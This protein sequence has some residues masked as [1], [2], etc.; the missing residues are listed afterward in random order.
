MVKLSSSGYH[1]TKQQII[2]RNP[3]RGEAQILVYKNTYG[4][5]LKVVEASTD[6]VLK[7]V[8]VEEASDEEVEQDKVHVVVFVDSDGEIVKTTMAKSGM[9]LSHKV[10]DADDESDNSKESSETSSKI[11]SKTSGKIS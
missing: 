8:I 9:L 1:V 3:V 6:K 7:F 2:R 11:N 4:E 5:I 10:I